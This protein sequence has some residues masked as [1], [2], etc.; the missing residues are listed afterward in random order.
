MGRRLW[1][2]DRYGYW[3]RDRQAERGSRGS[4]PMRTVWIL[5]LVLAAIVVLASLHP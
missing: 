2:Q 4:P 3:H 5:L 1:Y